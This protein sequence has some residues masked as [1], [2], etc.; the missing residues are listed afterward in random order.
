MKPSFFR[1]PGGNSEPLFG[2]NVLKILN[3]YLYCGTDLEGQTAAS[4]WNWKNTVID[5][6]QRPGRMGD[7]SYVNTEYVFY[8]IF[9]PFSPHQSLT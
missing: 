3:V 5:R 1:F 9:Q 4:R 2:F 8:V 6:L 7:W